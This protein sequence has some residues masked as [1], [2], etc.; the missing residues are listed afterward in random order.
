[1]ALI[2]LSTP[3]TGR[4]NGAVLYVSITSGSE[5]RLW[6]FETKDACLTLYDESISIKIDR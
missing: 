3:N 2:A 4:M 1:M 6:V 5:R